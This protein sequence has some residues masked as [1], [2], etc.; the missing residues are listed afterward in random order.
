MTN[1]VELLAPAGSREAFLGAISAGADAVYLAGQKFGARAYA[2][3]FT[4]EELTESLR[5]AHLLGRK[6]YLTV[7]TLTREEELPELTFGHEPEKGGI[8]MEVSY[9]EVLR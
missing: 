7:N 5:E 6:I 3:N 8:V 4:E 2:G 1:T 9:S